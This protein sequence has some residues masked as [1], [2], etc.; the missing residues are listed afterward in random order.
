MKIRTKTFL[1]ILT[2]SVVLSCALSV[3]HFIYDLIHQE[4][5]IKYAD[6]TID[7]FIK[8]NSELS[9]NILTPFSKQYINLKTK[10]LADVIEEKF[11]TN[12]KDYSELKNDKALLDLLVDS[13]YVG[14][15]QAGYIAILNIKTQKIIICTSKTDVGK[16][17]DNFLKE[18]P[19]LKKLHLELKSNHFTNGYYTYTNPGNTSTLHEFLSAY[20]IKNTDLVI[21]YSLSLNRYKKSFYS[22]IQAEVKR[23][24]ENIVNE[25]HE[26]TYNEIIYTAIFTVVVFLIIY[27]LSIPLALWF[28]NS[29]TAPIV[30]LRDK[31][32]NIGK[33]NFNV[34]LKMEGS[35]ETKD[36]IK[37]FNYL[38]EELQS[39]T[40]NLTKEVRNR[41]RVE[42]ELSIAR[43][44]QEST[45]PSIEPDFLS[46]KFQLGAKLLPAAKVAG[47]F[48]D[49][50]FIE[51]KLA[52]VIAD[53][54]GKGISAAFFMTLTKS[55]IANLS[56]VCS[57]S[58]EILR[59]ANNQLSRNNKTFM[60]TTLF[61]A[62]YDPETG[63]L[64]YS[65]AGHE[66]IL[67]INSKGTISE[68]GE[69]EKMALGFY[70][71]SEY[72]SEK[73]TLQKEDL[74]VFF[75]DGIPDARSPEKEFYGETRFKELLV[76][77]RLKTPLEICDIV[78]NNVKKFENNVLYD[79]ITLMTFK[80]I[81]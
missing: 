38:G 39:Y 1:V 9:D 19:N 67:L 76:E 13:T 30:K 23:K 62:I 54:S 20:T 69:Q 36:L 47:D 71:E 70:K 72:I 57:T 14:K 22:T 50:F 78:V 5:Y 31:V 63:D 32:I 18:Y 28:S 24:Q 21:L 56:L 79:D 61:M 65:N 7:S 80:R 74:L 35:T 8:W 75:T 17:V 46:N 6:K 4:N 40:V 64:Q 16:N 11:I 15:I 66:N 52:L 59:K 68:L 2:V 29:I 53:V 73:I 27:A 44:I 3:S 48:Y 41:E 55:L 49:F 37:T 58:E 12:R 60:F 33:G 26:S 81:G 25:I 43:N 77:N 34:K 10:Y 42:T 51:D 45:L